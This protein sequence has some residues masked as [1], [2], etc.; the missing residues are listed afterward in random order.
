[1]WWQAPI[2]N[3]LLDNVSVKDKRGVDK[4]PSCSDCSVHAINMPAGASADPCKKGPP[5]PPKSSPKCNLTKA[6]GCYDDTARG[7][8]LPDFQPQTH[9]R[10]PIAVCAEACAKVSK[11]VAGIDGGNHCYCGAAS[12]LTNAT[13]KA[14]PLAECQTMACRGDPRIKADCG[15]ENRLIAYTFVCAA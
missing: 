14:K 3:I 15:G 1:L 13:S 2:Y 6:L 11:H 9:D 4:G 8:I 10:R 7:S 5:P 12:D